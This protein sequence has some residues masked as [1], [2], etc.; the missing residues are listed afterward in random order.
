MEVAKSSENLDF[1]QVPLTFEAPR[2]IARGAELRLAK[3]LVKGRL[4]VAQK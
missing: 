4:G 2:G 3:Q 1:Q